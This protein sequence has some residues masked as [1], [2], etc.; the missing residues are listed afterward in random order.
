[1]LLLVFMSLSDKKMA[2]RVTMR[3]LPS[4]ILKPVLLNRVV[5]QEVLEQRSAFE[6]IQR[7]VLPYL[8]RSQLVS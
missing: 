3:P 4:Q 1:M 8:V 7:D 2:H 5:L 6:S